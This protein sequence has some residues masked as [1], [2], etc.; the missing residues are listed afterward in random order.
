MASRSDTES[1]SPEIRPLETQ[2]DFQACLALQRET[3]G[4]APGTLVPTPLLLVVQRIGGVAAGAFD[5]DGRLL[6]FVFGMTGVEK[7]ELVHWSDMLAVRPEARDR[8][9]GK[10]LKEYQRE[11]VAHIGV[12]RILWTYDPLVAKNAWFN[13]AVLG[14]RVAEYV[15]EMYG[16]T[17][18]PMH[19]GIGTDRI[20]VSWDVVGRRDDGHSPAAS[21][22]SG[23]AASAG[24]PRVPDAG[25][26]TVLNPSG[27]AF[28]EPGTAPFRAAILIPSDILAVRE[29][30]RDEALR[31]RTSTRA[32]F[33]WA[34]AMGYDV[35]RVER[36]ASCEEVKYSLV[37][38]SAQ[39]VP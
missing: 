27:E 35:E 16:E 24:L 6:G 19:A 5:T 10:R 7:G 13:I 32:A 20:V 28:A 8:G 2:A 23:R 14:A 3:W 34:L 39:R 30:S 36:I 26:T 15:P 18:S 31:W 33:Q 12:R 17:G 4:D 9:L 38:R 21:G 1:S 11:Q 22:S 29:R 37:M 25:D